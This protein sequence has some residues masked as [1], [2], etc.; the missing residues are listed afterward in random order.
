MGEWTGKWKLSLP[1]SCK[2][3][4]GKEKGAETWHETFD[5]NHLDA[6]QHDGDTKTFTKFFCEDCIKQYG[7]QIEN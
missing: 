5:A 3:K 6:M 2:C 1:L 4:C 7:S